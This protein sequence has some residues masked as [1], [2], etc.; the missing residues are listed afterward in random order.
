VIAAVLDLALD[1][2]VVEIQVRSST[3][4]IR[5]EVGRSLVRHE[6]FCVGSDTFL[7]VAWIKFSVARSDMP[8]DEV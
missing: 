7:T 5:T 8:A 6:D 4:A 1:F 2:F 3:Q